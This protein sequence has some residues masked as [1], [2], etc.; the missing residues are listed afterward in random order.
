[1]EPDFIRMV[2]HNVYTT[3][4]ANIIAAEN[5]LATRMNLN[6]D[7]E[8]V[9]IFLQSAVMQLR[10]RGPSMQ[11]QPVQ[12]QRDHSPQHQGSWVHQSQGHH[13][14]GSRNNLE[15]EDLRNRLSG[16]DGGVESAYREGPVIDGFPCFSNRLRSTPLPYKFKTSNYSK[17]D[18]K[19]EPRQW[20][21]VYSIAS[22]RV[23]WRNK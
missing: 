18:G 7:D 17:Y 16:R 22:L 11:D 21:C 1:M 9:A 20:L 3:P 12:H 8:R 23:G 13:Q 6:P 2:G 15:P 4:L 5:A 10:G 19:I 14:Q